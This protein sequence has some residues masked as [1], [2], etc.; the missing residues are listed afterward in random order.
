MDDLFVLHAFDLH[1]FE[2]KQKFLFKH[3]LSAVVDVELD[4]TTL[5]P[6]FVN[7]NIIVSIDLVV[8]LKSNVLES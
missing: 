5:V 7:L 2:L 8:L 4:E 3:H 6:R 1:V